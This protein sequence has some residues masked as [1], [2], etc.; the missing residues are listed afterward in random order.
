[1]YEPKP[2]TQYPSLG[3]PSFMGAA[4]RAINRARLVD[5]PTYKIARRLDTYLEHYER[6]VSRL[7]PGK[8]TEK[9]G[10]AYERA[11][12]QRDRIRDVALPEAHALNAALEELEETMSV[13]ADD[14]MCLDISLPRDE[15]E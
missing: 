10:R 4:S 14:I 12:M 11:A 15:E 6:L 3:F 7:E 5:C 1:M 13:M 9:W 8:D 2:G